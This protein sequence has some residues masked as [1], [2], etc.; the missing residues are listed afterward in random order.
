[1]CLLPSA[2]GG[3]ARFDWLGGS[4]E[5][6]L[7]RPCLGDAERSPGCYEPNRLA[8]YPLL[9]WSNR[10]AHGGFFVGQRRVALPLNRDDDAYPIHG[11]G[12]QRR[13][14]VRR[15]DADAAHLE[16][17][18]TVRDAYSYRAGL[19]YRLDGDALEVRLD[20]TNTG[21]APL[22]FGLGLH[23]FFP[24]HGEA[25]LLAPATGIWLNDGRDP[26][27]TRHE[28]V[29]GPWDFSVDRALPAS[30]LNHAFTGWTGRATIEW[31][32]RALRLHVEAD[33]DAYVLYTPADKD[34][35]CF[36]PVD[37]PINAVHL[38]GGP[39]ANGMTLLAPGE[40]LEHAFVFR[41]E[42]VPADD[43]Q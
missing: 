35:F 23:P 22:P 39:T 30:G 26:L 15:H 34:F 19:H 28:G 13:W 2:G 38:P 3:I 14:H 18:E 1:M 43:T 4:E 8:C 42:A 27:P 5:V 12:W 36:E 11:S 41:V 17:V 37:H 10:I 33:V 25:R 20:V 40:S 29:P 24:L 21:D 32:R 7:M 16:L 6:P 31:P 9:P